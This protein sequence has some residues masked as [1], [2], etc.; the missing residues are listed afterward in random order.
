MPYKIWVPGEEV[1]AADFNAY[2]QQQVI[3]TFPTAAARNAAITSPVEGMVTWI[4]D[5]NR[6]EVFNGVAWEL[7]FLPPYLMPF[8]FEPLTGAFAIAGEQTFATPTYNYKML[9]EL[10]WASWMGGNA[11]AT[12]IHVRDMTGTL[13]GPPDAW[14]YCHIAST[15]YAAAFQLQTATRTA[16]TAASIRVE[17]A[18]NG[19]SGGI[20]NGLAKVTIIQV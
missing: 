9:I 5:T 14:T 16:G 19:S 8:A 12:A 6:L 17:A 11:Q 15:T 10:A 3:A 1:L 7:F 18:C 20:R 13:I 4:N 2:V